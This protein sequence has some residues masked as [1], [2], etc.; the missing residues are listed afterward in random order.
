MKIQEEISKWSRRI[1]VMVG[2][3][4]RQR[5]GTE[6]NVEMLVGDGDPVVA[7]AKWRCFRLSS[8]NSYIAEL[9][10]KSS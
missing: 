7:H 10:H 1:M 8:S 6:K 9:L 2:E 3:T 5:R 4:V